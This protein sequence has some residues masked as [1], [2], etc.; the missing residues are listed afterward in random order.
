PTWTAIACDY[1]AI[2]ASSVSSKRAVSG[3]GI[4]ISKCHNHLKG[5]IVEALQV[6][7]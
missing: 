5:N 6:V 7:K 2:M 1:L 3:G 4:T